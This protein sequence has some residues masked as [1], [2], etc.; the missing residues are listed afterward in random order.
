MY[1]FPNRIYNVLLTAQ[2]SNTLRCV[3]PS[4]RL[5]RHVEAMAQGEQG[6]RGLLVALRQPSDVGCCQG[7]VGSI[8]H[9]ASE[10]GIHGLGRL[11]TRRRAVDMDGSMRLPRGA[12]VVYAALERD[13]RVHG[14]TA[15]WRMD[16]H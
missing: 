16:V 7:H 13:T 10:R 5:A 8:G 1:L 4:L 2:H 12:R 14:D 15:D 11:A 3:L 9:R 6:L